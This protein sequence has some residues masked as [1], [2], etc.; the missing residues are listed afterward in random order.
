MAVILIVGTYAFFRLHPLRGLVV[1]LLLGL[2]Y[3]ILAYL[4]FCINWI[5]PV[6]S[7][8][9]GLALSYLGTL[10]FRLTGE[11]RERTPEANVRAIC[12]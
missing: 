4:L 10:G 8:H 5:Q 6:A 1:G 12:L 2:F 3:A 9:L 11:E 7:V